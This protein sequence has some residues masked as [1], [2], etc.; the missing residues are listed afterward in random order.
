MVNK[1][2]KIISLN[3]IF[4]CSLI[5]LNIH[6]KQPANNKVGPLDVKKT[7]IAHY[8]TNMLLSEGKTPNFLMNKKF[9]APD[10]VAK[11][12]GGAIQSYPLFDFSK[13]KNKK[14][15]LEA[16]KAELKAAKLMGI[17]AFHFYYTC[18][19]YTERYNDVIKT[20]FDAADSLGIDFKFTICFCNPSAKND[21]DVIN[22]MTELWND[23]FKKVPRNHKRWFKTKDGKLI[24]FLWVAENIIPG[25]SK[26][27]WAK[28]DQQIFHKIANAYRTLSKNVGIKAAYVYQLRGG[29]ATSAQYVNA[30]LNS[31]DAVWAWMPKQNGGWENVKKKKKKRN[32]TFIRSA[33]NDFYGS[34]MYDGTKKGYN[35]V[36]NL[37]K[38]EQLG[39]KNMWRF[40]VSFN[41]SKEFRYNL[42]SAIKNKDKI[43]SVTSWNDYP[44]G[45]QMTPDVNH[46]FSYGIL[47][48]YYKN[49]WLGKKKSNNFDIGLVFF[50]KYKSSVK[51]IYWNFKLGG[52]KEKNYSQ[53]DFIEAIAILKAPAKLYLR[54]KYIGTGKKGLNVFRIP[55]TPGKVNFAAKR[56][57]KVLFNFSAPEWITD[58]PYRT[59]RI[60]YGYSSLY[61]K[62][63][64]KCFGS[65]NP[66]YV[67]EYAQNK[68][69]VPKWKQK[70]KINK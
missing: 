58:E 45:H 12:I 42:T 13:G 39:I 9:Y 27:L 7:V 30:A 59:D 47:L 49:I 25:G 56:G 62:W 69:G 54:G 67:Q 23:L 57:N 61:K 66:E 31:F 52:D 16:A 70:Y 46:N 5:I 17:D 20:F 63:W 37:R 14:S 53:D 41:L 28:T 33:V 55:S 51:P 10:G 18:S 4:L 19:P 68:N 22:R 65:R 15:A 50:K 11:K 36:W 60:T 40:S 3:L 8:M 35:I 48:R 21:T 43:I 26:V 24:I 32:R 2:L 6:A 1:F 64:K 29:R 34:K 38:A 44:E